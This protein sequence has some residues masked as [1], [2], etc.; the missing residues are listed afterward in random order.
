MIT[1]GAT[2]LI[3]LFKASGRPVPRKEERARD[4]LAVTNIRIYLVIIVLN[5][6]VVLKY[7]LI[8]CLLFE[9]DPRI[10]RVRD[11]DEGK[12]DRELRIKPFIGGL[13]ARV[14]EHAWPHVAARLVSEV[15]SLATSFDHLSND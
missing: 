2:T 12:D 8:V 1:R 14:E 10:Q 7:L 9:L 3:V 13:V 4:V 11:A 15:D 5:A 6:T